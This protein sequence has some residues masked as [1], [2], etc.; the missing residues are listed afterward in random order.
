MRRT[1]YSR[2]LERA[3]E[4]LGGAEELRSFLSVRKSVLG[5]WMSGYGTP[6]DDVFLRVVD[7]LAEH[8]LQEIRQEVG[9]QRS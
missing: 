4:I 3:A 7:L 5:L 6:P 1:V 9:V 8:Q 2:A